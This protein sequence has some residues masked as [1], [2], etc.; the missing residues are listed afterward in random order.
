MLVLGALFVNSSWLLLVF[1][2]VSAATVA[3][4][5]R[6]VR[7]AVRYFGHRVS[8]PGIKLLLVVLFGLGGLAT[9]VGSEAVMPA[10][11]AGLVAAGGSS[12]TTGCWWTSCAPSLSPCSPHS[13]SARRR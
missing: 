5:P 7:L 6:L 3:V 10:Y 12:C 1:A 2:A 4:L 13:S 11:V 8:E 9:Q